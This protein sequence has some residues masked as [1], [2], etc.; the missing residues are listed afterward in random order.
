MLKA[1]AKEWL[2]C[3]IAKCRHVLMI[4]ENKKVAGHSVTLLMY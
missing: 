2:T 4:Y 3:L 1:R